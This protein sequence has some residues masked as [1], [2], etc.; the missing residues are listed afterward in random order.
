M[1]KIVTFK[2]ATDRPTVVLICFKQTIWGN[3]PIYLSGLL[4]NDA[5]LIIEKLSSIISS[6]K[7][8]YSH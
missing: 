6:G 7:Y 4:H 1:G 2:E 5:L 8:T 3:I